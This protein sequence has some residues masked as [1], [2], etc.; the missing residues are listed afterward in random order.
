MS[1][2]CTFPGCQQPVPVKTGPGRKS[3]YCVD[4]THTPVSA[5]RARK[6]TEIQAAAEQAQVAGDRTLTLATGRLRLVAESIGDTL[7]KQRQWLD[8]ETSAVIDALA[9]LNDLDKIEVELATSRAEADTQIGTA[10]VAAQSA[11]A[12]TQT[13]QQAQ[14]VAE[15]LTLT[16]THDLEAAQTEATQANQRA[17]AAEQAHVQATSELDAQTQ[18]ETQLRAEL[19]EAQAETQ[20]AQALTTAAQQGHQAAEA[21]ADKTQ[22]QNAELHQQI[23]QLQAQLNQQPN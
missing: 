21:R 1:E 6:A 11:A 4:P 16:A 23:G 18:V 19:Q 3:L 7:T 8:T 10:Q 12:D 15:Q 13:A 2:T 22:T 14:Q 9:D 20:T 17:T 5:Y